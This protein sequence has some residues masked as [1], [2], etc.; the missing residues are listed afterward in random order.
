MNNHRNTSKQKIM[1]T[2]TIIPK[3][4]YKEENYLEVK[5]RYNGFGEEFYSSIKQNLPEVFK[6]LKYYQNIKIQKEDSFAEYNY[7]NIC[8]AIQLDP[9][10]E[11][12]VLFNNSNISIEIGTWSEDEYKEGIDFIKNEILTR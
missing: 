5:N 12:I 3:T 10:C 11:V 1:T 8:F 6:H 4:D 2:D 7:E 9:L